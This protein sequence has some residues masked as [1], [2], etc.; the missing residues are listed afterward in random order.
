[1]IYIKDHVHY[2]LNEFKILI[3]VYDNNQRMYI[4]HIKKINNFC[5]YYY[6]RDLYA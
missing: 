1:M 5:L 2:L 6:Y 3:F 4:L